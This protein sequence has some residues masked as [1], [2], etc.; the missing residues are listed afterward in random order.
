MS[1]SAQG[2]NAPGFARQ[3]CFQRIVTCSDS[4]SCSKEQGFPFAPLV[5]GARTRIRFLRTDSLLKALTKRLLGN[6]DQCQF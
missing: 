2:G 5:V 4:H 6:L 1:K 3:K